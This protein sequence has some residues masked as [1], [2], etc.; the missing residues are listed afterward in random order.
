MAQYKLPEEPLFTHGE[1]LE[2]VKQEQLEQP[3]FIEWLKEFRSEIFEKLIEVA[4][5]VIEDALG[6]TKTNK[7]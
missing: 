4:V 3:H 7:K 1:H 2:P 6:V 5:D